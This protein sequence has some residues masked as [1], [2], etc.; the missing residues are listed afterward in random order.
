VG[1]VTSSEDL[2]LIEAISPFFIV[3]N[4]AQAIAFYHRLGF[5]TRFSEPAEHPFF[6][7]VGREGA[8]IF[9]KHQDGVAPTPN[10]QSHRWMSWDAFVY[11]SD[12]DELAVELQQRGVDLHQPLGDR[13]DGLRGFETRDVD[14]Y[15]LFFGRPR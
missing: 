13:D 6:A 10:A 4:V 9:L 5:E 3:R 11:V 1:A 7:I 2:R 12:P 15:I 14:G 8:Q